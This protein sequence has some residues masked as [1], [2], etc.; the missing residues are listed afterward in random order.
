MIDKLHHTVEIE[1]LN[2]SYKGKPLLNID[3]LKMDKPGITVV[4]G[5]NGAG[6]SLL[7]KLIQGIEKPT[8]GQIRLNGTPVSDKQGHQSMV[9][10]TPTFLRLS[11]YQNIAVC[12]TRDNFFL[13]KDQKN[14]I[15][16]ML[17]KVGLGDK[18]K[19]PAR[20]L[21]GGEKQKLSLARAL[22]SK[23]KILLVDEPTST[24]D[25][26]TTSFI[27]EIIKAKAENGTKIIFVTHDIHQALRLARH[28]IM[29]HNGKVVEEGDVERFFKTPNSPHTRDYL[30]GKLLG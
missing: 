24:I 5:P 1:N 4:L 22:I 15:L 28:A 11:V 25:P 20:L 8:L 14:E 29:I 3:Y 16:A 2:F 17:E 30:A 12:L 9:L 23:P 18:I 13:N 10:Q 19:L 21:S 6:K 26:S 27:E 7:L